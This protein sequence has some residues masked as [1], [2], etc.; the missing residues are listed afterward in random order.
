M[1]DNR[2]FGP[3]PGPLRGRDRECGIL[4]ALLRQVREGRSGVLLLRGAPG[5]GK[6]AL[7]RYVMETGSG[8]TLLRCTGVESEM[9]L[10]FAG[11]HELC[12]PTLDGL[13]SLPEPQQHALSTALGQATGDS[14]DKFL[15]ALA[16]LGLVSAACE[17]G[18]MLCI[19]EDA[20]WLDQASAQVLGFLGRRLL[21]EPIALVFAAR[22]PVSTPD[23]LLGLPELQVDGIDDRSAGA[24]LDSVGGVH[25]D[26]RIRARIIDEI[27]GNP[28]GLI[29]LGARM[30]TPGFA[31]GFTSVDGTS[32]THRIEDEYLVR[33]SGLPHDTQELMLLAAADPVCDTG[34]IRR[35]ATTLKLGADAADAA[36]DAGLLSVGA[37]VRFRHPLL[38]SAVYRGASIER[39]RAAHRA[40]AAATD[41]NLESD[42]LAWHRAYA[43][44]GP[45]E[46][47][48]GELIGSADRA[49][50]RGGVAATAAFLDR[51]VALTPDAADRASRALVA[52]QAKLI[53]GDLE[54]TGRLLAE[55]EAG[56]LGE[57]EQATVEL[58]RAQ[59]AFTRSRGRDAPMLLWRAATRLLGLNLDLAR[60][61]YLQALVATN[62]AGRLGDPEV[63]RAVARG[64]LSLPVDPVPTPAVQLLVRGI[65]IWMTDGYAAAAPILND[66]MHQ[67][68]NESPAPDFV[69]FAFIGMAVHLCDDHAWYAMVSGQAKLARQR[70]ML[71]WLPLALGISVD[72]YI[73]AGGLAQ[74]EALLTEADLIDPT[75]TAANSPRI[76]LMAAAWRGDASA[77]QGPLRAVLE[78][79]TRGEG[80]LLALADYAKAVL[81]NGLA[82]YPPAADAAQNVGA[83]GDFVGGLQVRALYELVEAAARSG[84]RDRARIAAQQLSVMA[85]ANGSDFAL[86]MAARSS[87]LI[88]DDVAAD[89][90]YWEAIERL[91]RTRMATYLARARL[92]Y[93]EWLRRQNRRVDA[94]TQLRVA[95]DALSAMGAAG[96]AERA[97]RELAATGEKVRRRTGPTSADLTPQEEQIAQLAREGRTNP[98]IGAQLFLS[99]RTVEWH[100]RKV[101][102]K[103]EISSRRELDAALARR[104]SATWADRAR[105]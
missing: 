82:D 86:G 91:G 1:A 99:A 30:S 103:L 77:A 21:A 66:A 3:T 81:S 70:G 101:F 16:A 19:V 12:A 37:S 97:R 89:E 73:Q 50:A 36:I 76:A 80:W 61:A 47:V 92:S 64:A 11:L 2:R 17:Q 96:F 20:H 55:A 13:E 71:S 87:A 83:D 35:A 33:L 57:L 104:A 5:I 23:H 42:R 95:H 28:L 68:L 74:A 9:E 25:I 78:A 43:A 88:A 54:A 52:A 79:A 31:G 84:Q 18:P 56:P 45:D 14:P 67:Y 32:L 93:G 38:R 58:L 100:L 46:E 72:F 29:E 22:A 48:A 94:R 24:L 34:L 26:E 8:L 69:G 4:D 51:A 75:I 27:Q 10:P 7:L 44:S 105:S 40:L 6:T 15:V 39:R 59:V 65:A 62:Y 60:L 102:T 53:A 90:L 63:R 49:Q 41:A 98:E 85:T